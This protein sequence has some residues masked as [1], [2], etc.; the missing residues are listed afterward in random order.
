MAA[1]SL[2]YAQEVVRARGVVSYIMLGSTASIR[3]AERL[4]ALYARDAGVQVKGNP[5]SFQGN[6]SDAVVVDLADARPQRGASHLTG[7]NEDTSLRLL[8]VALSRARG[9]LVVLMDSQF[10]M[11]RH[12]PSSPARHAWTR[13]SA[14]AAT[15]RLTFEA[16]L[17]LGGDG[18]VGWHASW[19]DAQPSLASDVARATEALVGH[20]PRGFDPSDEVVAA[21]DAASRS[22]KPA[23]LHVS[24]AIAARLERTA[25]DLRL[26]PRN[27]GLVLVAAPV[28]VWVGG[29]NPDLP[30]AR[31]AAAELCEAFRDELFADAFAS[32]AP[33][34]DSEERVRRAC[35]RCPSCG[36]PRRPRLQRGRGWV[37]RCEGDDHDAQPLELASLAA[38]A[39]AAGA[40]CDECGGAPVVR[41]GAR[42]PFL[43]C[44]N[45]ASGC[46][47]RPPRLEDLFPC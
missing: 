14:D 28:A 23:L 12:P 27:C 36:E 5:V 22:A 8:N 1:R 40:V 41:K 32:P 42:G 2:R 15:L 44:E 9:K 17:R 18:D 35:G 33:S 34:A 19:R 6:E 38:L 13:R 7:R 30:L 20:I 47:G 39:I 21:V 46:E 16:L 43:G 3:V 4:G 25:A 10:V 11:E 37:L 24:P 31:M 29:S 26:L 45:Y